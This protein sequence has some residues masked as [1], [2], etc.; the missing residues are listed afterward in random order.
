MEDKPGFSL[1]EARIIVI[2]NAIFVAIFWTAAIVMSEGGKA[3]LFAAEVPPGLSTGIG[4]AIM[5]GGL[6]ATLF[7]RRKALRAAEKTRPTQHIE[8]SGLLRTVIQ[9]EEDMRNALMKSWLMLEIPTLITAV[10]FMMMGGRLLLLIAV[11]VYIAGFAL[12][13]PQAAWFS[14]A[15]QPD[16][17]A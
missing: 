8:D 7:F 17:N 15:V 3:G 6:A 10:L 1:N 13:F 16:H 14:K 12:T 11:A 5:A 2:V 9:A 4:A